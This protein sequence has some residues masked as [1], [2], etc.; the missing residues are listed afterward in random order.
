[1]KTS[2]YSKLVFFTLVFMGG[3]L[4]G[5]PVLE[6]SPRGVLNYPS[7][8]DSVS[9]SYY[10]I[11]SGNAVFNDSLETYQALNGT[12]PQSI[13]TSGVVTINPGDSLLITLTDYDFDDPNFVVGQNSVVIWVTDDNLAPVTQ[14]DT[15]NLV[16][17][18]G[19]AFKF[20]NFGLMNFPL[21]ADTATLYNFDLHV[22][23]NSADDYFDT[24]YVRYLVNGDTLRNQS[25]G[26]VFIAGLNSII[27]NQA[28]FEFNIPP[29]AFG[30]NEVR[31][32]VRGTEAAVAIDTLYR[33][34]E[35]SALT[36]RE[37]APEKRVLAWP[38]PIP[39]NA[40]LFIQA[41]SRIARLYV[42]KA[43]GKLITEE[44]VDDFQTHWT[45]DASETGIFFLTLHL[46]NG[47]VIKR[48]LVLR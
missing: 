20:G 5:Q 47:A 19:P 27:Y 39:E 1:M 10:V 18:D 29:F 46:E 4:F 17:T 28:D 48:K 12:T 25:P 32:W 6:L 35:V 8:D 31:I 2:L 14:R 34:V 33:T 9:I 45:P 26:K 11:N 13:D 22:E 3:L 44:R 43:N 7:V 23:N 37:S 15:L 41:P 36:R 21:Q 38:N 16:L 42:H 30:S 40:N 24:L